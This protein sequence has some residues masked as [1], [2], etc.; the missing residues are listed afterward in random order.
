MVVIDLASRAVTQTIEVGGEVFSM[1]LMDGERTLLAGL[2][3]KKVVVID[4]AR[5]VVTQTIEVDGGVRCMQLVDG[6]RSLL[7][8]AL[9]VREAGRGTD[10]RRSPASLAS[11]PTTTTHNNRQGVIRAGADLEKILRPLDATRRQIT[12]VCC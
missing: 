5:R 4:L 6:E 11:A 8:R 7:A 9:R 2:G 1:Q 10:L 3:S 12:D